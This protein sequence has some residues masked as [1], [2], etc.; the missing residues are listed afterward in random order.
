M[1]AAERITWEKSLSSNAV[2]W[3]VL[4]PVSFSSSNGATLLK[5]SDGSVLSSGK[6]PE[7]DTVTITAN[8]TLTNITAFR[9]EVLTDESLPHKGPGR[10]DNGNLHLSEFRVEAA[11]RQSQS[12]R[13]IVPLQHPSADFDQDGWDISRAID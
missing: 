4:E 7:T 5:Q 12:N 13:I 9:L 8:V 3:T 6:R 11:P 2:V 1:L 10:Q